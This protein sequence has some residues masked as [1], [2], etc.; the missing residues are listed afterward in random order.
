MMKFLKSILFSLLILSILSSCNKQKKD[1][2][3][4]LLEEFMQ[5]FEDEDI[6]D[7]L[8]NKVYIIKSGFSSLD[9]SD[10]GLAQGG[11]T[12]V[13]IYK[14]YLLAEYDSY[15]QTDPNNIIDEAKIEN[16]QK[17]AF[18]EDNVIEGWEWAMGRIKKGES[19]SIIIHSDFAYRGD[20]VG[21]IPPFSTLIYEVRILD[22]ITQN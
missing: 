19:A 15:L 8:E 14:G 4:A 1:A 9:T 6:Y 22:I 21:L 2:E 13:S 12:I 17:Y 5:D 18:L 3:D 20:Q 11:D 16:P 7:R 10:I